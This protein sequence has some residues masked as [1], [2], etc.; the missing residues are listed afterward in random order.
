MLEN[1]SFLA[2]IFGGK[3]VGTP[4]LAVN[5]FIPR[6]ESVQFYGCFSLICICASNALKALTK[7]M[8]ILPLSKEQVRARPNN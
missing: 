8:Q 3:N 6:A 5:F 2:G 7:P 1:E 4:Y